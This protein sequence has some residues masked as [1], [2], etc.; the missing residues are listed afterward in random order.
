VDEK[1]PFEIREGQIHRT[2]PNSKLSFARSNA[3]ALVQ[4]GGDEGIRLAVHFMRNV[5]HRQPTGE[6][7]EASRG[8]LAALINWILPIEAMINSAIIL[9]AVRNEAVDFLVIVP[10]PPQLIF[11]LYTFSTGERVR[12]RGKES[13]VFWFIIFTPGQPP[14]LACRP[15][16]PPCQGAKGHGKRYL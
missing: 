5:K 4:P 6:N 2:G 1:I 8:T 15:P 16:S 7:L 10:S 9:H 12:V 13:T 11:Q 14:H 3:F